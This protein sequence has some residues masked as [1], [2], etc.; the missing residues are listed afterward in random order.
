MPAIDP[1][2]YTVIDARVG[3]VDYDTAY[4]LAYG[5]ISPATFQKSS[6]GYGQ[7]GAEM[8]KELTDLAF[9]IN[10]NFDEAKFEQGFA[11]GKS[12]QTQRMLTAIRNVA[13]T[14]DGVQKLSDQAVR[15][16]SSWYNS[17]AQK[18]KAKFGNVPANTFYV[19]ATL[20]GDELSMILG[21]GSA[22]DMARTMGLDMTNPDFSPEQFKDA[23]QFVKDRVQN[24]NDEIQKGIWQGTA[25]ENSGGEN[26]QGNNPLNLNL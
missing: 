14:I 16:N 22:T 19:A 21:T 9:Q 1:K 4:R 26:P 7:K 10:P 23:M 2:R 8:R 13:N 18:V 20:L 6:G 24:R 3:S 25:K 5:L 17:I 15:S 12:A 11:Y